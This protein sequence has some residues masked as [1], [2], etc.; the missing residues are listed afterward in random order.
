MTQNVS[1]KKS[2]ETEKLSCYSVALHKFAGIYV[3]CVV[4]TCS[5]YGGMVS[6]PW[7]IYPCIY[8]LI[9]IP[10]YVFGGIYLIVYSWYIFAGISM[11]C[12]VV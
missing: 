1:D 5:W 2:S 11:V 4:A 10:W 8:L 3:V 6:A 9:Y 12:V 7:F